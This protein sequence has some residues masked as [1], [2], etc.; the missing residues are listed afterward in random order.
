MGSG[1][2]YP[3]PEISFPFIPYTLLLNVECEMLN[4]KNPFSWSP[5]S[6]QN[7]HYTIFLI[8][9]LRHSLFDVSRKGRLTPQ[10]SVFV[11]QCPFSSIR[12]AVSVLQF[13]LI[14]DHC[15]SIFVSYELYVSCISQK[16]LALIHKNFDVILTTIS[17]C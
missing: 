6:I 16:K 3:A 12:S 1:L 11:L 9:E 15:L 7:A 10:Y 2:P 4:A 8:F 14:T 5:I 13:P 17:K